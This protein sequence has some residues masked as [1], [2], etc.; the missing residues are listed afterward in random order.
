MSLSREYLCAGHQRRPPGILKQF[1]K[2]AGLICIEKVCRAAPK[3]LSNKD[4]SRLT[5]DLSLLVGLS[6]S[7]ADWE[8]RVVAVKRTELNQQAWWGSSSIAVAILIGHSKGVH[9]GMS[10]SREYLCAG[11][12]RSPGI[13]KQF[14]KTAGLICI[15]KV[16][17]AAP[18][19][20]SNTG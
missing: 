4:R 17:R 10:R 13:L 7:A 18:K 11:H 16:C 20:L 9:G 2:T 8:E 6:R 5:R 12:Q 14:E 3:G 19:G 15:E 1:E